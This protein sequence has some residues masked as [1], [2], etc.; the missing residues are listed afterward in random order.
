[1]AIISCLHSAGGGKAKKITLSFKKEGSLTYKNT[2]D[3]LLPLLIRVVY[4]NK[5]Q[6]LNKQLMILNNVTWK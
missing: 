2:Y 1:M 3:I 4:T 6:S 5:N